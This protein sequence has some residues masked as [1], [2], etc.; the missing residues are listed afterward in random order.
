MPDDANE[1]V[2]VERLLFLQQPHDLLRRVV[3]NVGQV[4]LAA[5][6]AGKSSSIRLLRE[7]HR[8]R[9]RRTLPPLVLGDSEG[10]G[11]GGVHAVAVSSSSSLRPALRS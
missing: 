3:V 6:T 7:G 10:G 2:L 5:W 9:S 8:D 11:R 4:P 1:D